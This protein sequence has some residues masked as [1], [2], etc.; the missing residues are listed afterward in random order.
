MKSP[1]SILVIY[2]VFVLLLSSC[3]LQNFTNNPQKESTSEFQQ[4][5][6]NVSLAE[7]RFFLQIPEPV[8]EDLVFEIIDDVTGIELNPTRYSLQKSDDTHYGVIIPLKIGSIVKYRYFRNGGLPIYETNAENKIIDY[9]AVYIDSA[10]DF[11]DVLTNW[12]DKQY[13]YAY[14]SL[15]GQIINASSDSPLQNL[16][17]IAG[18]NHAFTDSDGYFLIDN[19]PPGKH[20][21]VALSTDGEYQTY[22]QEAIIAEGLNTP[23]KLNVEPE[24]FVNITFIAKIPDLDNAL[25]QPM[26][27]LG[28]TY[29]LGNVFGNVFNGESTVASRAPS[30]NLLPDGTYSITLSLPVGFN[31]VYKYSLG[32]GFWN[33]EL[34]ENEQFFT[35]NII[36]PNEDTLITDIIS[37]F[38]AKSSSPVTFNITTPANLP[39]TDSVSI[40]FSAFGWSS[41]IP[42]NKTASNLFTY[43]LYGPLNLM[44]S[45]K[46]R[47]C[48]NDSCSPI[49]S[50][51]SSDSEAEFIYQLSSTNRS[52][53]ISLDSGLEWNTTSSPTEIVAPQINNRGA[54]FITGIEFNSTY[55]IFDPIYSKFAYQNIQDLSSNTVVIP[56]TW[57]LQS[58][59]PLE[60]RQIAGKNPLWKDIFSIVNKAQSDG[61]KVILSPR[62]DLSETVLNQL[63]QGLFAPEWDADFIASYSRE[64]KY[65]ADMAEFMH[66]DGIV[67]P[68]K[69]SGKDAS[70]LPTELI[71]PEI[72]NQLFDIMHKQFSGKIYNE[73]LLEDSTP[74]MDFM[75]QFDGVIID[76]NWDISNSG[77]DT[78]AFEKSIS[79]ILNSKVAE[80]AQSY[81]KP[82]LLRLA[83]PSI[84]GS[85]KGCIQIDTNCIGFMDLSTINIDQQQQIGINLPI[86]S[87]IYQAMFS[88]LNDLDWIDGII[89][90]GFDLQLGLQ[91]GSSS[92]R[93]KPAS[94]VL[95]YWYPRLNGTIQ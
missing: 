87:Q 23:A 29:Q 75:Q 46:Y 31:L 15:E 18:G 84:N 26:R 41:P 58:I 53:E 2:I 92:I 77:S 20:N 42:M 60:L 34:N 67:F 62:V 52:L 89:S 61:L 57:S 78:G 3:S 90:A 63:E 35:R 25:T 70:V 71:N 44:D 68:E 13:A 10:R 38:Q 54:Q 9:R 69:V 47:F 74:A 39:V 73:F 66:I 59:N 28:N 16:L 64:I 88:Q 27:I 81:E 86:Q 30:L 6:E 11:S 65:V 83:Y 49:D 50:T 17:I 91:D 82:I 36:I 72:K 37:T 40:Q 7:S 14:G 76:A 95:W 94:D 32:N 22:Q 48:R 8:T 43:T 79:E 4:Y 56:V 51:S 33:A 1:F 21:L 12:A 55:S 93:E 19:L 85:E 80:F 5:S 24:K 45:I